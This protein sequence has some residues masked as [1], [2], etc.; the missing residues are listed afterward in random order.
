VKHSAAES[1]PRTYDV[2]RDRRITNITHIRICYSHN[3]SIC[4]VKTKSN[5]DCCNIYI[6]I[7]YY[8]TMI[9]VF[10]YDVYTC[11]IH[12]SVHTRTTRV[13]QFIAAIGSR[14]PYAPE[15]ARFTRC[16][17]N[18]LLAYHR[19]RRCRRMQPLRQRIID[20]ARAH[21]LHAYTPPS[22]GHPPALSPSRPGHVYTRHWQA[23]HSSSFSTLQTRPLLST[24]LALS[25]NPTN[26]PPEPTRER[27]L[28]PTSSTSRNENVR[29]IY[30]RRL[31]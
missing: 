19:R 3:R 16:E 22:D 26:T 27:R 20:S 11:C 10:V 30:V 18:A 9:S 12:Y 17:V 1:I 31:T 6:Y 7:H 23:R 24:P 14:T 28:S 21:P 8:N 4:K 2:Y 5:A 15:S 25:Q 13:T 29:E